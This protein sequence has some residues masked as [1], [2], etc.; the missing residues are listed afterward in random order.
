MNEQIP[1]F[2]SGFPHVGIN[3]NRQVLHPDCFG[4]IELVE[5][6]K[7]VYVCNTRPTLTEKEFRDG[8]RPYTKCY[9]VPVENL[10][11]L[12]LVVPNRNCTVL[13][14]TCDEVIP[15]AGKPAYGPCAKPPSC[16]PNVL[17]TIIPDASCCLRTMTSH[18]PKPRN[19]PPPAPP[20]CLY[21]QCQDKAFIFCNDEPQLP[22]SVHKP[23]STYPT[24]TCPTYHAQPTVPPKG[25]CPP[26][27][28]SV[29]PPTF[30]RVTRTPTHHAERTCSTRKVCPPGYDSICPPTF[31][32][33][34]LK[35]DVPMVCCSNDPGL[36]R[37]LENKVRPSNPR[38]G[39]IPKFLPS[40][41]KERCHN[42]C[43]IMNMGYSR[44]WFKERDCVKHMVYP[45]ECQA[46]L[47]IKLLS[48]PQC[49]D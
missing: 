6:T 42:M 21:D 24:F 14:S 17:P 13:P 1:P 46:P 7:T 44:Q 40:Y 19:K 20:H 36:V 3:I 11:Q 2:R 5:P 16:Y 15:A 41:E 9:E 28:D 22:R 38:D 49:G 18:T 29:C 30:E 12:G 35:E 31:E 25:T 47:S 45:Y 8:I 27:W 26:G 10:T 43:N 32:R 39:P 48:D 37:I 4:E 33:V 23:C 34:R